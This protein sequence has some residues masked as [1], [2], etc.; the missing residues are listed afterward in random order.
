MK[1]RISAFVGLCLLMVLCWLPL[2][3]GL[4][5]CVTDKAEPIPEQY[6]VWWFHVRRVFS[7]MVWG[8]FYE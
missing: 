6:R 3:I 2:V 7:V 4:C 8:Y 5:A 1:N